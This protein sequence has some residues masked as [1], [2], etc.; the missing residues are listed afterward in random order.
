M[1]VA[2]THLETQ[3]RSFFDEIGY[4]V[5]RTGDELR[6]ERKW[7]SVRVSLMTDPRDLPE[8]GDLRCFVTPVAEVERFHRALR[9]RDP[10]YDWAVVGVDE[11]GAV[12]VVRRPDGRSV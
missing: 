8:S 1:G 9:Q 3:A 4:T 2:T 7:R 11:D 10:S 5:S 12:E 6:A